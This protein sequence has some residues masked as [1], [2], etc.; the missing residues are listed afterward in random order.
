MSELKGDSDTLDF[1]RPHSIS[2]LEIR[3]TSRNLLTNTEQ[4]SALPRSS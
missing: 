4:P 3:T 1:R 2:M